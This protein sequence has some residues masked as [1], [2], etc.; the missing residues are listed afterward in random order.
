MS[1]LLSSHGLELVAV[2]FGGLALNLTPCVYPM[3]PVTLAFFGGQA[4]GS[5]QR[6]GWLALCYVFGLS[7]SYALLGVLAA[8]TGALFGSWLQQP[9]VLI[10]IALVII[11]LALSMF[12][13][14]DLRPP[15]VLTDR[16]GQASAGASGALVMGMVVGIVAAPCVGPFIISLLL[17]VGQLANP[18]AGFLLF[19]VLGL[20]MGLPYL[21]LGIAANRIGRLPK[22]GAWLVWSKRALGVVLLGV[23]LHFLW[24][25]LPSQAARIPTREAAS[26]LVRWEPYS[27]AAFAHAQAAHRPVIIDVYADWCIPCVEMDRVT[28]HHPDVAQALAGVSTLRVDATRGVSDEASQLLERAQVYGAP[29]ILLFGRDGRERADLRVEGFETPEEFLERLKRIL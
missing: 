8:R 9:A 14:Y 28:F 29:T 20:G 7:L 25:L 16:L 13:L 11:A 23:A 4:A 27:Q 18:A 22:A 6:S 12:G 19:F 26:S 10:V 5:W 24:P 15:R 21:V 1:H 2:F 3:I 17:L